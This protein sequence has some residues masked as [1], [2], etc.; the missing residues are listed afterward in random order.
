[1]KSVRFARRWRRRV[2]DATVE[3]YPAGVSAVVSN[4]RAEAAQR[5]GV[6]DGQPV[7]APS[8]TTGEPGLSDDG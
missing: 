3:E 6:L 5:A 4:S 2:N 8:E 1:M 7:D